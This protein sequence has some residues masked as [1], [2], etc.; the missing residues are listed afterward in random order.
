MPARSLTD[1]NEILDFLA[2]DRLY[3]AYAIGDL[4]P[5]LFADCEW[6][7]VEEERRLHAVVLLYKGLDPPALFLMGKVPGLA[8]VL[9]FG[10]RQK[11]VYITCREEHV[12]AVSAFYATEPPEAMWRMVIE[13]QD[14][15]PTETGAVIPLSPRHVEELKILYAQGG[16]DA[17]TPFQLATGVFYGV[18]IRGRMVAAAG[19]H[20][21]SPT[22]GLGAIGNVFTEEAYRGQGY[23]TAT[24]SA[25]VR[26]LFRR[27]IR[28]VVLNV[29]QSNATAIRIYERLGFAKHC[30]YVEMLAI[31]RG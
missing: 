10:F 20:L 17:F 21:I 4:E 9:R 8:K 18:R 26:E 13:P 1:K 16:G 27:G 11:R 25:V 7:G 28:S 22:Y 2:R 15:R 12:L 19:T 6:L 5:A 30:P 14:F 31:R 24:T 23:A 3:A 29:A